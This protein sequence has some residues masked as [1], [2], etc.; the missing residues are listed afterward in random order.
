MTVNMIWLA[1]TLALL[2]PITI[3]GRPVAGQQREQRLEQRLASAA[4]DGPRFFVQNG[5][6]RTV[7][8]LRRTDLLRQRISVSLDGAPLRDALRDVARQAGIHLMYADDVLPDSTR[9]HLR[10]E[11]ITVAAALTDLLADALVDV[12]FTPAGDATLVKRATP[13]PPAAAGNLTGHVKLAGSGAPLS[14]VNVVVVGTRLGATTAEDGSYRIAQVPTGDQTIVARRLGYRPSTSHVTIADGATATADFTLDVDAL[15]MDEVV[16]TGN[17]TETE[18]RQLGNSIGTVSSDELAQTGAVSVDRALVGKVPGVMV[19]QNSGNPGGG[20]SMRLRGTNT[21]LGTA[22]PLYVV[23]GVIVNNN[24]NTLI[25]AGGYAQNRMIDINPDDIDHIEVV[26][27]AAAAALY[28]SRANNGVVQIFTKNGGAGAPR[29]DWYST[30]SNDHLRKRLA[31]NKYP[32]D[33]AGNPVTRFDAQDVIFRNASGFENGGSVSGTAGD[34]RYYISGSYVND[35]GIVRNSNFNRATGRVRLDHSLTSWASVSVGGTAA[36]SRDRDVPNGGLASSLYGAMEGFLFGPNTFDPN[37]VNGV[38]G[39]GAFANPAEV[40]DKYAFGQKT[41][42]FIG[43]G[44]LTLTPLAG[45]KVEYTLGSDSYT[46]AAT[47]F[48]PR[49]VSTPGIYNLGF[50]QNGTANVSQVNNDLTATLDRALT[51]SIHTTTALGGTYQTETDVI[52]GASSYDLSP[53]SQIVPSGANRTLSESRSRQ[54]VQG[55]YGQETVGLADRLFLTGAYRVDA[56]SVFASSQRVQGY[57]KVSG[58]YVMSDESFWRNSFAGRIL[59][60]FKLRAAWGESGGLTAIGP[61]DRFTNYGPVS[62]EGN[63]GLLP[64]RQEGSDIKP[65]RQTAFETGLETSILSDRVG[66]EVNVYRQRTSDLLLTT[67]VALT[68]G[69]STQLQNVGTI[70]NRGVELLLRATPVQRSGVSWNTTLSYSANKNRVSDVPGGVKVLGNSYGL[71]AAVNGQPLGV[72]YAA[73]FKRDAQGNI[74]DTNGKLY[75]DAATQIPGTNSAAHI[76]GDPNPKWIGSWSNDLRVGKNLSFHTLLDGVFGNDVWNYDA[77]V[78]A[79]TA[80]CTLSL[81]GD[82]LSGKIAAGRGKAMYTNFEYWVEDGSYVKI[83]ELSATYVF[84]PRLARMRELGVSV[85]GR[86]LF[87]FDHYKNGYD[88]ETN[89][90]GQSTGTRG[91]E[92]A[93]VPIPRSIAFRISTSF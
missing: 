2:V 75:T 44:H 49:G 63:P 91:Y 14:G 36:V 84:H 61:F 73:G 8:D 26:K 7:V 70:D 57:P 1:R 33:A 51:P 92:F 54:I 53:V 11:G 60:Q 64:S 45:V 10:A 47:A 39:K 83:R 43:D 21:I 3:S 59:P 72:Y 34:T 29:F 62:Y 18:R 87:S 93:E 77:R 38:Y 16:V 89:A 41:N 50:A 79:N 12:V 80:Y 86:N 56:S 15:R 17:S 76:I 9:V 46:Q 37:P 27:G 58:S 5:K 52:Q 88:P 40:I 19:Q 55:V 48:I 42:R 24:S 32:F 68:T 30:Y 23:D 22:D 66:L 81:C 69:Y 65:E 85:I 4:D 31:V 74:L 25:Y 82:E 67:S 20:I 13:P 28:G 71:A 78:G 90:G 6:A 35:D